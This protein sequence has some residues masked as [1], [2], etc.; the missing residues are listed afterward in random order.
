[1]FIPQEEHRKEVE[2]ARA[3]LPPTAQTLGWTRLALPGPE[4]SPPADEAAQK[5]GGTQSA[6]EHDSGGVFRPSIYLPPVP[7]GIVKGWKFI[8]FGAC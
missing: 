4:A 1:M 7:A 2:E 5:L 3:Y 8:L 6:R